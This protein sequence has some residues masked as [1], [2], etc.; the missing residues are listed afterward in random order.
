MSNFSK[1]KKKKPF[2]IYLIFPKYHDSNSATACDWDELASYFQVF[3][4]IS[5]ISHLSSMSLGVHIF[6]FEDVAFS[7]CI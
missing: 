6:S 1:I 7:N 5:N 4:I 2:G 3:K